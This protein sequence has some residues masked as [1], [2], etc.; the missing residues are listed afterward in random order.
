M[1]PQR[2]FEHADNLLQQAAALRE[3][4]DDLREQADFMY[5]RAN[6]LT[7]TAKGLQQIAYQDRDAMQIMWDK[8]LRMSKEDF[9]LYLSDSAHSARFNEMA[10]RVEDGLGNVDQMN[11][12]L[13]DF[14]EFVDVCDQASSGFLEAGPACKPKL[15]R[16]ISTLNDG[17]EAAPYPAAKR[18][19]RVRYDEESGPAS[20]E[21]KTIN[22]Q[23]ARLV[24]HAP[25]ER[26]ECNSQVSTDAGETSNT[27]SD[28]AGDEESDGHRVGSEATNSSDEEEKKSSTPSDIHTT[29][30]AR[31]SVDENS[32]VGSDD[33]ESDSGLSC[34]SNSASASSSSGDSADDVVVEEP[35]GRPERTSR[36]ASA[37]KTVAAP[38]SQKDK[39]LK[40]GSV[41]VRK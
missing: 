15:K 24:S 16:R 29:T 4:A 25:A 8:I 14:L 6:T 28:P 39:K 1:T 31:D 33:T 10:T 36:T 35:N 17:D 11:E 41:S 37:S 21:D 12:F 3:K 34:T 38:T 22:G 19:K 5:G 13:S 40:T 26:T 23:A 7:K 27:D 18:L 9:E 32:S 2:A 30:E 20:D